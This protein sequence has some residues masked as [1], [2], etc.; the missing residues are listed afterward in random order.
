MKPPSEPTWTSDRVRASE[1][2]GRHARDAD[3][4]SVGARHS[5]MEYKEFFRRVWSTIP[6]L[7][8][9]GPIATIKG[10]NDA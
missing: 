6:I 3:W 2:G 8:T 1:A 5:K 10:G 9:G 7:S 4:L